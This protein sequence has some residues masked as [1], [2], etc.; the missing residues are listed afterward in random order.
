[1]LRA[2]GLVLDACAAVPWLGMIAMSGVDPDPVWYRRF[3][4]VFAVL[5]TLALSTV[6]AAAVLAV[7]AAT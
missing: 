1:M 5:V 3:L 2:V 4:H 6:T 7:T